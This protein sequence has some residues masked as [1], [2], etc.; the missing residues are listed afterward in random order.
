MKWNGKIYVDT[1][2]PFG[3]CAVPELF[4]ILAN[5]LEWIKITKG[6]SHILHYLEDFLIL[7]PPISFKCKQVL[8][9][10]IKIC[11]NLRVP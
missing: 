1:C 10:I 7:G 4:N 11:K 3:L 8:D 6:V 5:L 9:I 2:L